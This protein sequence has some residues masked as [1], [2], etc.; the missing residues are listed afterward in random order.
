MD[1]RRGPVLVSAALAALL[2]VTC[3][4]SGTETLLPGAPSSAGTATTTAAAIDGIVGDLLQE[5]SAG[6][7]RL[8]RGEDDAALAGDVAV[9]REAGE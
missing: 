7:E 1:R 4:Q 3:R 9:G 5:A 2:S 6:Q 8:I